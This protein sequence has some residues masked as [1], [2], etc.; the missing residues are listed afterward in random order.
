MTVPV[1]DAAALGAA[2]A[3]ALAS[4]DER[5]RLAAAGR[6]RAADFSWTATAATLWELYRS[7]L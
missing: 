1:G 6:T 2:L 5:R 4:P 7:L 3:A